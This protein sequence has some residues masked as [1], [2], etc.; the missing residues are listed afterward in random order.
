[1]IAPDRKQLTEVLHSLVALINEWNDLAEDGDR[2]RSNDALVL[3]LWD[4]GSGR[5]GDSMG[6]KTEMNVQH[7][8]NTIDELVDYLEQWR[9]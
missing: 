3:E 7:Q 8:F 6:T 1:M 4:D 9:G 2:G 5:I